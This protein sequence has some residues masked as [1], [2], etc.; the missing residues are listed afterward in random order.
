MGLDWFRLCRADDVMALFTD[1]N[2][3]QCST[4]GLIMKLMSYQHG[5]PSVK[6]ELPVLKKI[7][8]T[9]NINNK[10]TTK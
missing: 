3:A 8:T 7:Y 4:F 5:K 6:K 9:Q 10:T 1:K 2:T